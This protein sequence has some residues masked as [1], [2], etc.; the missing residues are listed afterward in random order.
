MESDTGVL[1]GTPTRNDL[2]S[3][4]VNVTVNDGKGGWDDSNFTL[5]VQEINEVPGINQSWADFSFDEDTI[6]ES[7]SLNDWFVDYDGDELT[8]SYTGNDKLLVTILNTSAVRLVP[9][10]NWSGNEVLTFNANDSVFQESDSVTVTVLPVND[11]PFNA[12]IEI[13]VANPKEGGNQT[14]SGNASDVDI[15][16]GDVLTYNWSSNVSGFIGLGKE[17][18]LS[19][20]AGHHNIILNVTDSAG[21]WAIATSNI[22]ILP[23]KDDIDI[24]ETDTDGDNLPDDWEV[25]HFGN[26]SQGKDD[27]PDNDTFTNFQE[28]ENETDPN[29]PNDYPG[30]TDDKKDDDGDDGD[31]SSFISDYSW[32]ILLL[33]L[34]IIL[35]IIFA[36]I[37]SRR[38]K[39]EEEEV[40][41]GER[42]ECPDCGASLGEAESVCPACGVEFEGEEERFECP[43]CGATVE[44]GESLCLE[45]GAEFEEEEEFEADELTEEGELPEDE[46][47]MEG[48]TEEAG[49]EEDIL[50]QD[51][52]VTDDDLIDEIEPVIEEEPF[53]E[54]LAGDEGESI[55]DAKEASEN[56]SENED[57]K[58]E[59]NDI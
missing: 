16:Y 43:D 38:K 29:D 7:I 18:N 20:E 1:S 59:I 36:F 14:V 47:L 44:A 34:I 12:E 39:E 21:A 11:A 33:F 58:E 8:F 37:Y 24:N 55:D 51:E 5:T 46:A 3:Y 17:I 9:E 32:L 53:E 48:E 27:D 6:D 28:W 15:A 56:E 31:D 19:L 41:E 30:K 23:I 4:F 40:V 25:Y 45:C 57:Q 22:E 50:G 54:E 52:L 35:L 2:G 26:L 13:L 10:A 42:F 49:E